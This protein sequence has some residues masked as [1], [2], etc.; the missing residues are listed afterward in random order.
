MDLL[1]LAFIVSLGINVI[2]FIPAYL[3]KT[4]KLTDISYSI[5]FATLAIFGFSRS[6]QSSL[7]TLILILVLIWAIRLGGF[8]F[9]RINKVGKDVRFDGMRENFF[10]F[11]KFWLL[12]G[13][14]VF[15]IMLAALM[16]YARIHTSITV[17]SWIGVVVFS[18]GLLIETISDAQKF[19][20]KNNAK[21]KGQWIDEGIWRASRHPNYLGEI[22]VWI[23]IYLVVASSLTGISLLIALLSPLFIIVLLLFVSGIPLLEKSAQK[24]WGGQEEYNKYKA[25][26]PLLIPSFKSI[27]RISKHI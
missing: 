23:G 10:R 24:K 22:M 25:E 4:D 1:V 14:S 15:V 27:K 3:F 2:M 18:L 8:L 26:V 13:A 6:T 17:L 12:Q 19:R 5:T 11:L 16:G 21:H 20:F 9:I 7:H